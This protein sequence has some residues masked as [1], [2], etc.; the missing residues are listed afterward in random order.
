MTLLKPLSYGVFGLMAMVVVNLGLLGALG[1]LDPKPQ[2]GWYVVDASTVVQHFLEER[3]D[4]LSDE[5]MAGA[6]LVF[7][8]LVMQE[9]EAIFAETGARLVNKAHV[10]AGAEDVSLPFAE[11]VI[12]RWDAIQ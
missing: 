12:A 10:L 11:R 2:A 7:D 9:A 1:L 6:I 8:Q 4:D 3:G 5:E